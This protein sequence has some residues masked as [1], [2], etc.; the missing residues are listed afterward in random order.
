[1]W[2]HSAGLIADD[3][4][5]P[6][7]HTRIVSFV[8]C[9]ICSLKASGYIEKSSTFC[10]VLLFFSSKLLPFFLLL[11][12]LLSQ[13]SLPVCSSAVY[14][15]LLCLVVFEESVSS[16]P[17][18]VSR[19]SNLTRWSRFLLSNRIRR[20]CPSLSTQSPQGL[21]QFLVIL[22]LDYWQFCLCTPLD[23]WTDPEFS[24]IVCFQHS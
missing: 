21:V 4:T 24:W 14:F 22:W 16:H 5:N 13:F 17:S 9:W 15:C 11:L 3:K 19:S 12:C 18:F 6:H 20:I 10:L 7:P 23:L 8:C 1:M 2:V